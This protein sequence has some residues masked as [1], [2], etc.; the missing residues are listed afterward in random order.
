[1][2][3]TVRRTAVLL[4]LLL[5]ALLV[6]A[7]WIQGPG[8][9]ALADNDHNRRFAL[10]RY[11]RPLGDIYAGGQPLTGSEHTGSGPLAYQRTYADG[12]LYAP[13]T[14]YDSQLYGSTLLERLY[15][16]DLDGTDTRM[17]SPL[18]VLTKS[19]GP[20][21]AVMTTIDPAVQRAGFAALSG[22]S[23]GAVAL[24]PASGAV[25][26]MVSSPSYDPG[27]ISGGPGAAA[28]WKKLS[29]DRGRAMA[30]LAL[31]EP[32]APGSAFKLVT[33]AAALEDGLY[34]S[35]DTPTRSPLPYT[36]P[37]T[38]TP[39]PN[40]DASAPCRNATLRTAL[41]YSC[42][43]VF[44]NVAHDLGQPKMLAMARK[45]GFDE[46]RQDFPVRAATSVYPTSAM[47]ESSLALTGIGQFDVTAT[48]L[49]MAMVSAAI[50]NDGR[51]AAP[52]LVSEVTD[53]GG[54]PVLSV[55]RGGT[56]QVISPQTAEQLRS[57]METVVGK[58]SGAAA[59][60]PGAEVG[61]KTGTAQRGVGNSGNPYAWFTAYGRKG[62]R[63]VA[64]AVWIRDSAA[65]RSEVSGGRLAAPVAARMM[66]A[67]L[68]H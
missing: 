63:Q 16:G 14:G 8:A 56:S 39:L 49:Q 62:D 10:R 11:A 38:R 13:V 66:T 32:V 12:P 18:D 28:A 23:G 45:F 50:V 2:N 25:L 20:P 36:L 33:A 67:A 64:V 44:A 4:L 68:N 40:E 7:T 19:P 54:R 57:A 52:Y 22:A 26:A 59:R 21:G 55:P 3:R 42:N 5:L 35:V 17:Q 24:D 53:H 65:A 51:L 61:G 41:R 9:G 6:R 15:R 31:R 1:M 58:G 46:P 60:V 43:N 30:N 47:T 37:G 34:P 27:L 29:A 48:P